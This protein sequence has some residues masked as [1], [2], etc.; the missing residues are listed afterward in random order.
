MHDLETGEE[1]DFELSELPNKIHL[2]GFISGYQQRTYH[3]EDP[4]NVKVAEKMGELHDE[5]LESGYE[6]HDLE[7]FLVRLIYCL[8]A[9]DTGIFPKDHFHYFIEN[10]TNPN[11]SDTGAILATHISN[12]EQAI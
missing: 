7:V 2:F 3:D 1:T 10:K 11:G 5:L 4:V 6:G 8:F 12:A 9:D